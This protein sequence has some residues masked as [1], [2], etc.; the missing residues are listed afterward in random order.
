MNMQNMAKWLSPDLHSRPF[1]LQKKV[2]PL[3]AIQTPKK[4][5]KAIFRERPT[6]PRHTVM[7][8]PAIILQY[9]TSLPD[10]KYLLLKTLTQKLC[11]LFALISGQRSQSLAAIE[12]PFIDRGQEQYTFYFPSPL[13][14]SK[15]NFHQ[16]PIET[17]HYAV[18][19][20]C[21]NTCLDENL[22]MYVFF[23]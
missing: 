9:I 23:I 21:L 13:K 16:K 2:S 20:L 11:V 19:N 4:I 12:T 1:Y 3:A 15:P 18:T 8:D 17:K 10:N 7:Y 6:L 5:V 22:N 14:T